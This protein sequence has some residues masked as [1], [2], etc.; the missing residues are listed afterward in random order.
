MPWHQAWGLAALVGSSPIAVAVLKAQTPADLVAHRY[1][2]DPQHSSVAFA[3]KILGAVRVRGR[4]TEYQSSLVYDS[5][6]PERS[7][8]STVIDATS[9]TTDMKFRDD[10]LRS[11]DFLDTKQFPIIEFQSDS[12][13]PQAGGFLVSGT[14]SMHGISRRITF[15]AALV[16]PPQ[17]SPG[18]G[19]ELA[20][21]A[22][23]R[24]SRQAFGIAGSNKFNPS[25]NPLT[26][27]LS[28]S[29]EI[30]LELFAQRSSYSLGQLGHRDPPS[31]ADTVFRE[32]EAHGVEPALALYR[33]L[34]AEHPTGYSFSAGQLDVIGHILAERGRLGDATTVLRFNADLFADTDG[35]LESLGETLA[36][37]N[38]GPG[39]LAIY[40]QA[41]ERFPASAS[42]REM[43][44]DLERSQR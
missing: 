15:P 38:D 14:L 28:D 9:L 42:A 20:V 33:R 24:L 35:V 12:I 8:V 31:V 41:A 34:K 6:H 5:T 10:H 7:S 30:T 16:L 2:A 37:A 21:S 27:M 1:E 3:A 44:R 32:L 18:G 26:S 39:A 13:V 29:V 19:R 11:P 36:L 4:F 25:Y 17:V 23:L 40:R 22:Q 43:V